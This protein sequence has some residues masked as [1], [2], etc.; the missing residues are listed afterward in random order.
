M[1][2]R[3]LSIAFPATTEAVPR[4][5]VRPPRIAVN[6]TVPDVMPDTVDDTDSRRAPTAPNGCEARE[7]TGAPRDTDMGEGAIVTVAVMV[8]NS[9]ATSSSAVILRASDPSART[10][11]LFTIVCRLGSQRPPFPGAEAFGSGFGRA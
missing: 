2:E 8:L 11:T 3:T 10:F 6:V 5:T 9:G 4:D 1:S 7:T